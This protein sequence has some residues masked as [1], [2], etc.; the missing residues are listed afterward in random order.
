MFVFSALYANI[1]QAKTVGEKVDTTVHPGHL[2]MSY[3]LC[4]GLVD[5]NKSLIELARDEVLEECGYDVP[6][7]KFEKITCAR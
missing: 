5:K 4:A 1:S 2:G 7:E 6:V 3:E